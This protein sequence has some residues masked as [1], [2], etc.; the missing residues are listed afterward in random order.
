MRNTN[1]KSNQEVG[2]VGEETACKFLVKQGFSVI[3]RNFWKKWGEIDIIA[4]NGDKLHFVEVK[5]VS[6]ENIRDIS[7]ETLDEYRPEENVHPKKLERLSRT[8]QTYLLEKDYEGEWQFDVI[9]V[10]LDIERREAKCRYI[11]NVVL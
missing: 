5:T 1:K 4:Q 8:I 11:E 2:R 9:A 3:G 10:F 7:R 6:R